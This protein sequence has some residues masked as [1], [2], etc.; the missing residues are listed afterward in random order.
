MSS[1]RIPWPR[2]HD[3]N[4]QHSDTNHETNPSRTCHQQVSGEDNQ[5]SRKKSPIGLYDDPRF[6]ESVNRI[7]KS[8]FF[9]I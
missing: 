1:E 9:H 6:L 5:A 8:G 2:L 3:T 4:G 7:L